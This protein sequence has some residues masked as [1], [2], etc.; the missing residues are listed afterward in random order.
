MAE[1][2]SI[3]LKQRESGCNTKQIIVWDLLQLVEFVHQVGY[4]M[5]KLRLL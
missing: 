4:N 1:S 3:A 5:S 2:R